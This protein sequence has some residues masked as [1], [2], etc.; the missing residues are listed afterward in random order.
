MYGHAPGDALAIYGYEAMKLGL[1]TIAALGPA[2]NDK[3]AVLQALFGVTDRRSV[4]GTYGFDADGDT[5]LTSYGLYEAD[6][7][8]LLVFERTVAASGPSRAP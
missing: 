3:L 2:G 7:D 4:L 8:G 6:G 1:A 5:T